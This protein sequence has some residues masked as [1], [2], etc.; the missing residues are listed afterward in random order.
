MLIQRC[1]HHGL[2]EWLKLQMFY[3]G[4]D[5]HARSALDGVWPTERYTYDQ[6]PSTIKVVQEDDICQ[7]ILDRL[8]HIEFSSNASSTFREDKPLFH[9]LN[10]PT[11]D[12]NYIGIRED[13]M[14]QLM[15][16]MGDIKRQIGSDMPSN[17]DNNPR[18]E[19]KENVKAIALYSGKVLSCLDNL[20][21]EEIK[22]D[23]E[24]L[25][26]DPQQVENELEPEEVA[27]SKEELIKESAL[28]RAERANSKSERNKERWSGT[29]DAG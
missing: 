9:Y 28:K 19:G 23:T 11:E 25:Q 7:Q 3:N 2:P 24:D 22:E 18:R 10:N 12:M 26:K 15:S 20:P 8:N 21:Q 4:L 6:R 1:R 13:Q 16:M 17:T 5:A 14:S 29:M 27:K